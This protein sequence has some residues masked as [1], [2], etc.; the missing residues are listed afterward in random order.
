MD[1]K[2]EELQSYPPEVTS[3]KTSISETHGGLNNFLEQ[4]VNASNNSN[5][6]NAIPHTSMT[7]PSTPQRGMTHRCMPPPGMPPPGIP[8]PGMPPPGM[9]PH[10]IPPPG[11]PPPGMPPPGIPPPG[12]APPGMPPP[13]M[14]PP[15][16]PPPGV[17]PH[18]MPPLGMPT[19]GMLP[20]GMT[21]YDISPSC[22]TQNGM[23][24][25]VKSPSMQM[26]ATQP[27][28]MFPFYGFY[29]QFKTKLETERLVNGE[30]DDDKQKKKK[31]SKYGDDKHRRRRH[32]HRFKR[33]HKESRHRNKDS[34]DYSQS[35]K[36]KRKSSKPITKLGKKLIIPMVEETLPNPYRSIVTPRQSYVIIISH[37]NVEM[38]PCVNGAIITQRESEVEERKYDGNSKNMRMCYSRCSSGSCMRGPDCD[39]AHD[40]RDLLLRK[41]YNDVRNGSANLLGFKNDDNYNSDLKRELKNFQEKSLNS[42]SDSESDSESESESER[43]SD[44]E[45]QGFNTNEVK[46]TTD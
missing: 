9:P 5:P 34:G 38:I 12:M 27:N 19:P 4:I 32:K 46:R 41:I 36:R 6:P 39:F 14:P 25:N 44:N 42:D 15:G 17:L 23:T 11:M 18:C 10:G 45:S 13:G 24:H 31:K 3:E 1:N 2:L 21:G 29:P 26:S 35:K 8:P 16:M 22:L 7:S 43:E 20:R 30:I 37:G 33:N 28:S 40:S